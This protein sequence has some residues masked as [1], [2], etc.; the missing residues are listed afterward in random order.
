MA[1]SDYIWVSTPHDPRSI[2]GS[3]PF[4]AG[5][6]RLAAW[7]N[8]D[9]GNYVTGS[10]KDSSWGY[11]LSALKDISGNSRTEL[12]SH[13]KDGTGN[14]RHL[15]SANYYRPILGANPSGTNP[16]IGG[17]LQ[18]FIMGSYALSVQEGDDDT[19]NLFLLK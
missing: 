17:H 3:D 10:L 12:H 6:A 18:Q 19:R 5:N 7:Y 15:N 4:S 16:H 11:K 1:D 14:H 13:A 2:S 8:C 9:L